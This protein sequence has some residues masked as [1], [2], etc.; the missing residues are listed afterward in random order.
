MIEKLIVVRGGGDI[1]TGTIYKLKQAG[2][3]VLILEVE[4]PSAIRRNVAFSE[5]VYAGQQTVENMTCYKAE[6]IAHAEKMLQ[7]GKLVVLVDEKGESINYFRPQVVVDGILAKKNPGT[8]IDMACD[9]SL[10]PWIYS[11]PGC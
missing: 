9:S 1:A 5:A 4:Y 8:T 2:F 7:E 10:G 6:D 11:W 3:N